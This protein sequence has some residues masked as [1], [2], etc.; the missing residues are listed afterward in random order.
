MSILGE[1]LSAPATDHDVEQVLLGLAD[2]SYVL[3]T[4]DGALAECGVGV[5]ALLGAS[6]EQLAGRPVTDVLAAATD[7]AQRAAF[8]RL[9]HG[10][11]D[12]TRQAFATTTAGGAPRSLRFVVVS[13]PLELGWE[14]TSLLGELRSRDADT[15]H[16]EA[17]RLRHERALEAVERVCVTGA[18][19]EPGARLA[20]ILIV[21]RDA[22]APPLTR[23][24]VGQRMAAQRIAVRDAK[25]VS[26]APPPASATLRRPTD[27][28]SRISSSARTCCASASGRPSRRPPR[29]TPSASGC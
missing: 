9:L 21:V 18:Q 2:G 8:E 12:D 3:S 25:E 15:W 20:G 1:Q 22:A 7:P 6:A 11:R 29:R 26:A 5:V 4:P 17:L 14:F 24:D 13:V 23:E 28:G 16:P 27:R 19:P 10:E